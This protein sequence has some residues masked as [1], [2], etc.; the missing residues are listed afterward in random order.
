M[1]ARLPSLKTVAITLV[2]I[3]VAYALF[4]WLLLPRILQSQA[5][6]YIAEKTGHHLTLDRPEFNPF[7]LNLHLANLHLT[8]PDGK[9]LFGFR[10]L[11]VVLSATSIFQ[12]TWIINNIRLEGPEA[13]LVLQP[14]GKLN[15]SPL[16]DALKSKE[17]KPDAPLPRVNIEHFV[18]AGGLLDF[19]DNRVAFATRIEP[20]N[21]ELS[22]I[23]TLPDDKGH[24]KVSARTA[25]GAHVLWQ[26]DVSLNPLAAAGSFGIEDIDLSRLAPY[27]KDALPAGPPAGMAAVSTDYQLAYAA[28]QLN[29]TLDKLSAKLTGLRL[30]TGKASGADIAVDT[31]E[32]HNGHYDLAKN[33]FTLD[34]LTLTG[35]QVDL[36]QPAGAP[37][38]LL[39]LA[40]LALENVQLDLTAHNLSLGRIAL[41]NGQLKAVRDA[42][43][44]IDIVD[45]LQTAFQPAADAKPAANA[46][47]AAWHYRAEKLELTDF[48][49]AFR[50]QGMTPAVDM[51]IE[52]I[53]LA[54]DGISDN[55]A[56]PLPVRA[57]GR[58]RDGGNFEAAGRI[59]PA[60]PSADLHFK[61]ADLSLKPAQP[62]LTSLARLKLASGRLNVD[63]RATY[64]KRGTA[65]TGNLDLRDLRL[66]ETDTGALFLAWKSLGSRNLQATPTKLDIGTLAIDGLDAK[67]IIDKNKTLN[68]AD[69][70]RKPEPTGGASVSVSTAT[71]AAVT[72]MATAATATPTATPQKK[73]P[74]FLVNIDRLRV[75]HGEM[76][77]ADLS[78]ALPFGARIH[79]LHGAVNG[80][81]SRPGVPSQVELDGQV[82]DY[83]MARAVGQIALFNPTD[84]MDLK[85]IFRN[86]EMTQLTPYSATFAGRKIDSGKLSLDLEYKIKK[87][88]LAGENKIV[89]EKLVL[90]ERVDSPEAKDLPLDLAIAILQD[91]D[92]RIDLGLPVSGSMDDPHFSYGG[93]IWKAILNVFGKIATAPFRMLGA[94]FGGSGE[95][96]ESITFESGSAHLMPP[97]REKLVQLAGVL[98]KRPGLSLKLHGVYADSDRV[99]L[100]DLQLRRTLAEQTDEHAEYQGE[101]S[102]A[103]AGDPG[104]LTTQS[105]KVQEALESLFSDRI[106]SSEL[107][108]LKEGFR[109]AN[110]GQMEEGASGKMMSRLSGLFREKKTLSEQEM[111]QMKGGDFYAILFERLRDKETVTD[112]Q[113]QALGKARGENVA[114]ALK[115]AGTP[116]DRLTV[117]AT[118]KIDST[119]RNVSV[120]LELGAAP[121]LATAAAVPEK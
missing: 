92:G 35:N 23:S 112:A 76:D 12:R 81:S 108:A 38:K 2:G 93:I 60:E 59:I 120:K 89:M 117:E 29:L 107:A 11:E 73:E 44:N 24:Y 109:K 21:L 33:S 74:P 45:A 115:T 100:Q 7:K 47:S 75:S 84:F 116:T 63:G 28:G 102:K 9:P 39:Q 27:I 43:G 94:L 58:I 13:T 118:E 54:V 70:L 55:L 4:G 37:L 46:K 1:S 106:G 3:I 99:S 64:D 80:I 30:K 103:H 52:N 121:K 8:E 16:I 104:P 79:H 62:Y 17:E 119:G 31:I 25:F 88:Q 78:L 67:L 82:D 15:W 53:A 105:P 6:K 19:T 71:P 66:T 113:L 50:D 68:I 86:V 87:R 32:V 65:F 26:G 10:E 22:D 18:M 69:I 83:G 36:R 77:F 51:A 41:E 48:S 90:G 61:L 34:A 14:D 49:A 95:K 97:E 111:A 85:V 91:S 5:E 20:L 42:G 57:S 96:F 40:S 110:P 101:K 114:A 72:P 56:A 98:N